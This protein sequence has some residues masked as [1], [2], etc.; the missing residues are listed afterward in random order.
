[1]GV[2]V[3]IALAAIAAAATVGKA[4]AEVQAEQADLDAINTKSK[5]TALQYQQKNIQ[6]LETVDK[7]LSKQAAQLST[8]GVAFD[9]PSFNA[10]QRETINAGGKKSSN[11]QTEES[12]TNQAYN[13]EK[14]NVRSSLHAQLFGD[15]ANFAFAAAQYSNKVPKTPKKLP[16][17]EDL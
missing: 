2:E 8:R 11:L 10:I 1:M 3:S 5:L 4:S 9:S 16:Q 15:A 14:K 17:A 6:N 7:L 13:I 12:L